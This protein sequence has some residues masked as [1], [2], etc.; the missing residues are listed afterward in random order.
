MI[1]NQG[2]GTG[3]IQSYDQFYETDAKTGEKT[4]TPESLQTYWGIEMG[5]ANKDSERFRENGRDLVKRFLDDEAGKTSAAGKTR[6]NLFTANVQ[7]LRSMLYGRAPKVDVRRR[8]VDPKDDIAR[9][10]GEILERLL[11]MDIEKD[12]DTFAEALEHALDDRLIV[13]MGTVKLR[14]E[15]EFE[16]GEEQPAIMRANPMTGQM[17]EAA[18]AIPP[19]PQKKREEVCT[20]YFY[21]D[22]VR[23][24]PCRTWSTARWVGFKTPMTRDQVVAEFGEE[25]EDVP[26]DLKDKQKNDEF[27]SETNNPWAR[28]EVWEIWSKE[29]RKVYY[30]VKGY[31]KILRVKDD[32]LGLEG[33]WPCPQP[34]IAN[35]TTTRLMP[36]ADF[37]L[38]QD[39]YDEVDTVSSRITLLEQAIAARGVYDKTSD[40]IKRLLT[41]ASQNELIPIDEF[42][43]FAEKGGLAGVVDW[44]PIDM[45]ANALSILRDYRKELIGLLYQVTGFSDIMRGEANAGQ[46]ATATEQALKAKFASVR[47]KHFQDAF[48]KFASEAQMIKAE[49]ISKLYSPETIFKAANVQYMLGADP[50]LA[51]QAIQLVKS[52]VYQYRVEVKPESVSMEDYGQIKQERSE[53]LMAVSQFMQSSMPIGQ[54]APWAVPFLIQMMQW[55][56]AGFRG[57]STIEGVMDQMVLAAQQAQAQAAQQAQ[58]RGP[59]PPDPKVVA[60]QVKGQVEINKAKMDA[61]ANMQDHGLRMQ[62]MQADAQKSVLEHQLDLAKMEAQI[63]ADAAKATFRGNSNGGQE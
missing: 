1:E 41:E 24:S 49:I 40:P 35:L 32:P 33:F 38:A 16:D 53:F 50:Q 56:T 18:P 36:R 21:W 59:P 62:Q 43:A 22:D 48:A 5:S 60:A 10:A 57:G 34:L 2:G 9:I 26:L 12:S 47:M 6:V 17:E 63:R 51:R 31:R 15:A 39:L 29:K 7:T 8:F 61:Q 11:N 27:D 55:A 44:L 19:V 42:P 45:F 52:D 54:A 13:G 46:A 3:L 28:V 30:Y 37:I 20:D 14:Y 23:W 58:M 25:F 4:E